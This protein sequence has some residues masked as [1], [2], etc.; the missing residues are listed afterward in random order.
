MSYDYTQIAQT[1][2]A[3]RSRIAARKLSRAYD[4]ALKPVNLRVTQFAVL[5]AAQSSDGRQTITDLAEFLGLERSGLSRNLD[6]LERRGLVSLG[7][8][9]QHRARHVGITPAG[10]ALLAAAAPL[11][12]AAQ[13][14][15]AARL[16]DEWGLTLS[17]LTRL[18]EAV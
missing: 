17:R 9:K 1:C 6:P 2:M 16:G 15:L 7:P 4:D 11:W 12:Q 13:D 3:T 8:E 14:E 18:A 10:R 5:V